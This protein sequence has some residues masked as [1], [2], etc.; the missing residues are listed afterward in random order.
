MGTWVFSLCSRE[1][2][3]TCQGDASVGPVQ[4]T[5]SSVKLSTRAYAFKQS[6]STE[7]LASPKTLPITPK[8]FLKRNSVFLQACAM[9]C[10]VGYP[11]QL[12]PS[13]RI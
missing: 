4:P 2:E 10:P 11:P 13:C 3:L 1:G 5:V 6:K 8:Q 12:V 9:P 7:S